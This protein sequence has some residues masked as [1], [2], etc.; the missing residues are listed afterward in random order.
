MVE[1]N[2]YWETDE[3]E[4][5]VARSIIA[6]Y[7]KKVKKTKKCP[8]A[9][10]FNE[11]M[12]K[13]FKGIGCYFNPSDRLISLNEDEKTEMASKVQQ[14]DILNDGLPERAVL[15]KIPD[16]GTDAY[17][18]AL[19]LERVNP[20]PKPYGSDRKGRF[21]R[22]MQIFFQNEK[23]IGDGTIIVVDKDGFVESC[24][25]HEH[26]IDPISKR[27]IY[28]KN[29]PIKTSLHNP[30]V[31]Y[32][33]A[34]GSVTIQIYQDRRYLWNVQAYDGTAKA[35][36]GVYPEQIKSLFYARELPQTQ[37]GRKRPILHWVTA[38][39]RRI[40][41]GTEFDVDQYLR[42]THEF[43]MNGTKFK[44]TNPIKPRI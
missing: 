14:I 8:S 23:V 41:S 29:R 2:E 27:P 42:G 18:Y 7:E 11:E 19:Y 15:T 31:D 12:F 4:D 1:Y 9:V 22:C 10:R 33:S 38:H 26:G 39:Q 28:V 5:L 40:K 35:T 17:L 13:R 24:Y 36:F 25:T 16:E 30:D 32:F 44:I 20:L 6:L 43:I 37:T 21:Y 34:W 3:F